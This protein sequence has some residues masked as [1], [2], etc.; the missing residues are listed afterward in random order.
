V[1]VSETRKE[2][3]RAAR[4]NLILENAERLLTRDGFQGLNLDELAAAVEYS[5]GTLYLHFKTKEDL[6]LAV[7]TRSLKHRTDLL[8]R[9]AAFAGSTRDR[10]RAMSFAC[11]QFAVTHREY[12]SVELMLEARSFWERVSKERQTQHLAEASRLYRVV[13]QLVTDALS[14]GDLPR[15]CSAQEVTLS[16]IAVT[17][18]SHCAVTQ[19]HLQALCAVKDPLAALRMHQDRMLDGWGWKPI[20]HGSRH[21]ALDRRIHKEVFPEAT[22]IKS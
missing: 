20:S 13:N 19:P 9:A 21:D 2:R 8:E 15:G 4:E 10:A 7:A 14:C 5:K 1:T 6:V 3:E 12:F 16:L 11:C 22:W 17:M 18:G